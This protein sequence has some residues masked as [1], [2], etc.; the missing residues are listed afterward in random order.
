MEVAPIPDQRGV[1]SPIPDIIVACEV[2]GGF[3]IGIADGP[4]PFPSR[5]FAELIAAQRAEAARPP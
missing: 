5:R 2:G 4:G 1:P 3:Q